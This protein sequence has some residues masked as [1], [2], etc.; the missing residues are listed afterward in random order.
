ME[1]P[2]FIRRFHGV[3]HLGFPP[4]RQCPAEGSAFFQGIISR[5][6]VRHD[7]VDSKIRTC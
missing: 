4:L 5:S 6:I 1:L 3:L 7:A 2:H